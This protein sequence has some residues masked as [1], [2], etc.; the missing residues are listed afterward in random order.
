[1]K[2]F[3][4]RALKAAEAFLVRRGFEIIERT[5]KT[6][7]AGGPVD[8][9]A[10]DGWDLVFVSVKGRK[11]SGKGFPEITASREELERFAIDWFSRNPYQCEE[12]TFR[13]DTI[14]LVLVGPDRALIR[15]HINAMGPGRDIDSEEE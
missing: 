9:V 1:M 8:I 13:F 11:T 5:W 3:T 15:Q 2:S 10:M 14:A 4:K 7:G 12:C 6:E